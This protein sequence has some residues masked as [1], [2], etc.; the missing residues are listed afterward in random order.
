MPGVQSKDISQ[1]KRTL[2]PVDKIEIVSIL[3]QFSFAENLNLVPWKKKINLIYSELPHGMNFLGSLC[4]GA[5]C[6]SLVA[7]LCLTLL[8]PHDCNLPG[9][10]VHGI[11][12]ARILEWVAISFSRGSFW[13]RNQ[14]GIFCTAGRFFTAEPPGKLEKSLNI[15]KLTLSVNKRIVF[16]FKNQVISDKTQG[17]FLTTVGKLVQI[18]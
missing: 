16:I 18:D 12:Q 8:Q 14:T 11:P 5:A 7:K 13:L 10:S 1:R 15:I 6:Y 3:F 17:K 9:S 2:K 4:N